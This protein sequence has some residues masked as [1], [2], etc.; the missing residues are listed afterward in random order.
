MPAARQ[1]VR[2][3]PARCKVQGAQRSHLQVGAEVGASRSDLRNRELSA[4]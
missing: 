3:F 1:R 2:V 4:P